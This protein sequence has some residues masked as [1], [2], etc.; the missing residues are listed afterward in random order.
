MQL[1]EIIYPMQYFL[2]F[3]I[4]IL[5]LKLYGNT[6][7]KT[8]VNDKVNNIILNSKKLDIKKI[9][10]NKINYDF[11]ED[12][13]KEIIIINGEFKK[14]EYALNIEYE[15][16]IGID[17]DGIYYVT[18]NKSIIISTQLEPIYARTFFPCFDDPKFKSTFKIIIESDIN[19]V[20]LSNMPEKKVNVSENTKIVEFEETPLMSTYLVCIIVG[21][22]KKGVEQFINNK[23]PING[24]YFSETT[25][26]LNDSIK[27]TAQS[28]KYYEQLFDIPYKLQKLDVVAIPNFLSGAMENWGLVTFRETGLMIDDIQNMNSFINCIE[29]IYHEISHQWFGN[30]VTLNSWKDIW[31]NEANATY[32]SWL[33]LFDNY[34][35]LY[36]KQWYYLSTFRPAMLIDGF[37]ATHPISS[38]IMSNNDVLQY[39]D[40]ISYSK[41]SCLIN[42]LSELMGRDNFIFGISEYLKEYSWKTTTPENLYTMLNKCQKKT[43]YPIDDLV[44]KNIFI[45]GYPLITVTKNNNKYVIKKQKFLFIKNNKDCDYDVSFPLKIKIYK[46]NQMYEKIIKLSDEI[47]LDD[48][49]IINKDNMLLCMIN[50]N[51]IPKLKHMNVQELMHYIDC[52]YYL[53]ISGYKSF[54][55]LYDVLNI[56]FET[57]DFIGHLDGTL[58]LFKLIVI[59]LISMNY[60]ITSINIKN[61]LNKKHNEFIEIIKPKI[62]KILIHVIKKNNNMLTNT[63]L[64]ELL[65]FYL[66]FEDIKINEIIMKMFDFIYS[67]NTK[68]NFK[69]FPLHEVLFNF[70]IKYFDGVDTRTKIINI[71]NKSENIFIKNSATWSLTYSQNLDFL[72]SIIENIF[73]FVKL[74]D[75]S[76]ITYYLSKNLLIQKK[77]IEL[78]FTKIK[79]NEN[80]TFQNFSHIV[81]RITQN[82]YNIKS[83]QTLEQFYK[84]EKDPNV[85]SLE[86]DKIKWHFSIIEN[87]KNI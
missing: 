21:D 9:Y 46:N 52:V 56:V 30:L 19:K 53:S 54:W 79:K 12:I 4:D 3:K 27:I 37:D 31:L 78:I 64:T 51:Y 50:Y 43:I 14:G 5:N 74:Q 75:I 67:K 11:V 35:Y 6:I 69:D 33:G 77:I 58:C 45:K 59:N 40:E 25:N 32:F 84:N 42:Y 55:E 49:P 41:G 73:D 80:I 63:W 8:S 60:K 65:N 17:M 85:Y 39:F 24:Y 20:F 28:I 22:L 87:I 57:I 10:V 66:E 44:K 26:Q 38:D 13:T 61:S 18:Q 15:H 71:K 68:N 86:L 16:K 83:L 76:I 29:V 36:P 1:N 34:E 47:V 70:I 7:I 2:Y 72:N 81:E 48:E 62:S 23:I 82:I